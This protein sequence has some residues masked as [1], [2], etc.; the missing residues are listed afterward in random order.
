MPNAG[1]I[2]TC[3]L[4]YL[5]AVCGG[6]PHTWSSRRSR[7]G[8]RRRCG[9]G[10]GETGPLAQRYRNGVPQTHTPQTTGPGIYLFNTCKTPAVHCARAETIHS[11]PL[12]RDGR[13]VM[14]HSRRYLYVLRRR[15]VKPT[16]CF[17]QVSNDSTNK[18]IRPSPFLC[19]AY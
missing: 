10:A 17:V 9:A 8:F 4:F 5:R 12:T 1:T 3:I 2:H 15:F 11:D 19:G 6:R 14:A 16:R 13:T 7:T 18:C